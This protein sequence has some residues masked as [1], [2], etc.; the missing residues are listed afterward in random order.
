MEPGQWPAA[1]DKGTVR[2]VLLVSAI[3]FLRESLVEI[4]K[5]VAGLRVCGEAATPDGALDSV[6]STHPDIVLVDVTFPGGTQTG[7]RIHEAAPNASLI[8]LGI[9]E[10]EAD[11]LSWAEVGIAGYVPNT[12]SIEKLISMVDQIGHG[13]QTCPPRIAGSLLRRIYGQR[14]VKSPDAF[15]PPLLTARELEILRLV[16]AGLS[17]KDIARRLNVSLG[18]TKSHVHNIFGKLKLQRR[19][20]V[21]TGLR[22]SPGR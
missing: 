8:V 5:P 6:R 1:P 19:A 18:T 9:S 11:V 21:I 4:L 14:R 15:V 17:N 20:E 12:A 10:T 16:G 22:A 3:C 2:D 13:E 7:I